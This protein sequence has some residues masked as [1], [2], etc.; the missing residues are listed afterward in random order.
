MQW[1]LSLLFQ[2]ENGCVQV[3]LKSSGC[4]ERVVDATPMMKKRDSGSYQGLAVSHMEQRS[5]G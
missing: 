2:K 5:W 1:L 4:T 3:H